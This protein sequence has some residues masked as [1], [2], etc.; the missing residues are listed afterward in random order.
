MEIHAA[1]HGL[2]RHSTF[3]K[4]KYEKQMDVKVS[5]TIH[6]WFVYLHLVDLYGK[7]RNVFSGRDHFMKGS[8]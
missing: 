1:M 4:N 7:C 3:H 5:H 2:P 8:R 6:V